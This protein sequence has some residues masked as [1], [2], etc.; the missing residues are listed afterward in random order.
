MVI[1]K[2]DAD[3]ALNFH[4]SR[5]SKPNYITS[6]MFDNYKLKDVPMPK[7]GSITRT[8]DVVQPLPFSTDDRGRGAASM[9]MAM[10]GIHPVAPLCVICA[11]IVII[12]TV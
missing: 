4:K 10:G 12:I 7:D 9:A 1:T 11:L 8:W 2:A 6:G 3:A 5:D